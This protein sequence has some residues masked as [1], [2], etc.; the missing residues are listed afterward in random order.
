M[1]W[2]H[3]AVKAKDVCFI[4]L[5]GRVNLED[6]LDSR[7]TFRDFTV[8]LDCGMLRTEKRSILSDVFRVELELNGMQ[9]R[10]FVRGI[11]RSMTD[12]TREWNPDSYRT[13]S[14]TVFA[15]AGKKEMPCEV[16]I[17]A[18][19]RGQ[20]DGASFQLL[21]ILPKILSGGIKAVRIDGA[22]TMEGLDER[23]NETALVWARGLHREFGLRYNKLDAKCVKTVCVEPRRMGSED[24]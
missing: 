12:L 5:S 3:V 11:V 1:A 8:P 6:M 19:K 17:V 20:A 14:L 9:K 24:V 10:D 13:T 21:P 7:K 16:E 18:V 2:R 23:M 4:R 15:G 22:E